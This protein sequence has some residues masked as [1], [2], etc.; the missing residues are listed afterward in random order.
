MSLTPTKK[1]TTIT[2]KNPNSK[3][4]ADS[5]AKSKWWLELDDLIFKSVFNIVD[6]LTTNQTLR[7][8]AN[9]KFARLYQN[10]D[11]IG[12]ASGIFGGQNSVST[13]N[14]GRGPTYNVVKSCVD[15]VSA[16][17]AKNKPKIQFLTEEG[18]FTL[19]T[20]AKN[21]TQY[22]S[23][24]FDR[25]KAYHKCQRI[26]VDSCVWGTGVGYVYPTDDGSIEFERV[27]IQE[28][29]IDDMDAIYGKPT[30]IHRTKL[31]NRDE[32][33][34]LFPKF[35][36]EIDTSTSRPQMS[37]ETINTDQIR[38]IESW[39]IKSGSKAKDGK[40]S[41]CI[42]R[43]TLYAEE[44]T[45]E[46][47]PF[48][49]F[50]WNDKLIGFWGQSLAEE[51]AYLQIEINKLL[52]S[53]S[54][55]QDRMAIP[56]IYLENGSK[57]SDDHM[58]V[59]Q[60][61][62]II[63]YSGTPPVVSIP[64][65]MSPEIYQH[66]ETLKNNAYEITGIS[67]LS[68][69]SKK[70]DGLD[71]GIAIREVN[72]IESERFIL[73][74]QRYEQLFVDLARLMIDVSRDIYEKDPSLSVKA[75]GKK[76]ISTIN[77]KDVDLDDDLYTMQAF[78]INMLPSTP[79]GKI[80]TIQNFVQAGFIPQDY[81]IDLLDFPDLAEFTSLSTAGLET[82]KMLIENMLKDGVYVPPDPYL[83]LDLTMTLTHTTY[84]R[85]L[86]KK[87]IKPENLDLLRKFMQQIIS[88]KATANQTAPATGS[89]QAMPSDPNAPQG[90]APLAPVSQLMPQR[91]A[92]Q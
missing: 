36:T 21:L 86:H 39:H 57:I 67:Q 20:K 66:I 91:V 3:D 83:D 19:E 70:P 68:A 75:K 85:S 15:S 45:K 10:M 4:S 18:D 38:V 76:F 72:D 26:F 1:P 31:V 12:F 37:G 71:S 60:I 82:A 33:K 81:A 92:G 16:K 88:I 79:A 90:R 58:T 43:A 32:L 48:V 77:W 11:L 29:T 53:V 5:K 73:C 51:L 74:G 7:N 35:I 24:Q 64:G 50:H 41:I 49:F 44:Y 59:N 69:S 52:R 62:R 40:Y 6:R 23:G 9:L 61:A 65:A 14:A 2:V 80:A 84:L 34:E 27:F 28:L 42:D 17:I 54:I 8:N 46:G 87:G 78:P 55:A 63:K 89:V 47:F 30:S 25:T 56:T 13:V 22:I